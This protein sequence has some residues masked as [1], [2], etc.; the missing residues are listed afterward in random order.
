MIGKGLCRSSINHQINRFRWATEEELIPATVFHALQAG[1][2]LR[3]GM[4]EVRESVQP[5]SVW[6]VGRALRHMPPA[7]QAMVRFQYR[8][9]CRPKEVCLL[10][11]GD[12]DMSAVDPTSAKAV[13]VFRPQTH[14]RARRP[15]CGLPSASKGLLC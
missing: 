15:G 6:M 11:T 3:K 5:V 4:T 13:W 2:G 1:R 7:V 10:R 14:K 12:I 9:G 8:T